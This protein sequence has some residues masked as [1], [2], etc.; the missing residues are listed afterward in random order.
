[1]EILLI[2]LKKGR[3]YIRKNAYKF[4]STNFFA[5]VSPYDEVVSYAY[6]SEDN[7][8]YLVKKDT[9]NKRLIRLVKKSNIDKMNESDRY[10]VWCIRDKI[11]LNN[12]VVLSK[13]VNGLRYATPEECESII[14]SIV[15]DLIKE[16]ELSFKDILYNTPKY[17]ELYSFCMENDFEGSLFKLTRE[18]GVLE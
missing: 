17:N 16:K 3:F 8:V 13:K 18:A 1:M 11:R 4:L 15:F 5:L 14:D 10:N 7:G 2:K 6:W 12:K 9:T